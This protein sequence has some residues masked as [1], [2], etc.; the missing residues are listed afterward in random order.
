MWAGSAK[1]GEVWEN[2]HSVTCGTA[3]VHVEV[4]ARPRRLTQRPSAGIYYG[5]WRWGLKGQWTATGPGTKFYSLSP[6][7]A[8]SLALSV[9]LTLSSYLSLSPSLSR[10]GNESLTRAN[11]SVNTDALLPSTRVIVRQESNSYF[12]AALFSKEEE[13][14][15]SA[16][17][18]VNAANVASF[19]VPI[20]IPVILSPVIP[21]YFNLETFS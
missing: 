9:L 21:V 16:T 3:L 5:R 12:S 4:R 1:A 15:S 10:G 14:Y 19:L 8:L 2:P 20:Y 13:F 6:T 17:R 7:H 11:K 18:I